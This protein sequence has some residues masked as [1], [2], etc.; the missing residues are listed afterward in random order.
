MRTTIPIGVHQNESGIMNLDNAGGPDTHWV[1]YAKRRNWQSS[2]AEGISAILENNV[3]Q[4]EYN[5]TFTLISKSSILAVSYFPAV[6]LSDGD[7][8]LDLTDFETYYAIPNVNS[9]NNKF[10]FVTIRYEPVKHVYIV[11]VQII[12]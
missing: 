2:I 8:E 3:T 7:Y 10:Y 4:I 11:F 6:D 5:R 1:A 9:S 12:K